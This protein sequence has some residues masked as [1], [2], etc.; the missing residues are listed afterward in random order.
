MHQDPATALKRLSVE[1]MIHATAQVRD[2]SFGRYCEVGDYSCMTI[3]DAKTK[4]A[5]DGFTAKVLP[6]AAPDSA[7]V[8]GQAPDAG[9]NQ[10]PGS[11]V[12]ISAQD[13]KPGTC[14]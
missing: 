7:F 5:V 12:T 9:T 11:T 1:P 3:G 8:S 14:P 6:A 13:T 10:A 2:S 4:I